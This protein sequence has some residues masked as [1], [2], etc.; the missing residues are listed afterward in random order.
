[1]PDKASPS[2]SSVLMMLI[3]T[4]GADDVDLDG[5]LAATGNA[6]TASAM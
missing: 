5:P 2:L 6:T 4:R 1:L 3:S